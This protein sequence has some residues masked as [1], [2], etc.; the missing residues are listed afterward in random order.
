MFVGLNETP[1][2]KEGGCNLC[3]SMWQVLFSTLYESNLASEGPTHVQL[4]SDMVQ[5]TFLGGIWKL[6]F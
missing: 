6:L 5:A 3:V 4:Q 2:G 1:K